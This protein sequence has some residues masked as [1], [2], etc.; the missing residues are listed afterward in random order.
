MEFFTSYV[1]P[2]GFSL[3]HSNL[4]RLLGITIKL[5]TPIRYF[6]GAEICRFE[7]A[8]IHSFWLLLL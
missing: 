7:G 3:L 5:W 6:K 4:Q 2:D 1:K 8:E